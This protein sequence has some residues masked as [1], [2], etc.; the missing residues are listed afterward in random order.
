MKSINFINPIPPRKQKAFIHW[1]IVSLSLLGTTILGIGFLHYRYLSALSQAS[2]DVEVLQSETTTGRSLFE[3]K[4]QHEKNIAQLET[5]MRMLQTLKNSD[6]TTL[7][8]FQHLTQ[9]TPSDICL[10]SL[11]LSQPSEKKSESEKQQTILIKGLSR[12]SAAIT[13]FL[14]KVTA[15]PSLTTVRI[16]NLTS[17]TQPTDAPKLLEFTYQGTMVTERKNDPQKKD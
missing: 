15:H 12:T 9:A 13:T 14:T 10:T 5:R 11:E 1:F 6:V 4:Q 2:Y 16:T 3:Q 8:L 17:A 7:E